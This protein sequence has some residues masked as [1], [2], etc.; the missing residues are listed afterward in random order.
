MKMSIS[1]NINN[2]VFLQLDIFGKELLQILALAARD[3]NQT[4]LQMYH[5]HAVYRREDLLPMHGHVIGVATAGGNRRMQRHPTTQ[6]HI[7]E[8]SKNLA[9]AN[10]PRNNE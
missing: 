9:K 7:G 1:N 5:M 4:S 10:R 2:R 8:F 6:P 3:A